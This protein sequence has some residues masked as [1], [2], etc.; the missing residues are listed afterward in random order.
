[1]QNNQQLETM[2]NTIFDK[3]CNKINNKLF[4]DLNLQNTVSNSNAQLG[5][6]MINENI[7]PKTEVIK[8]QNYSLFGYE[9]SVWYLILLILILIT[10]L[11]FV[12]KYFFSYNNNIV[13]IQKSKDLIQMNNSNDTNNLNSEIDSDDESTSKSSKSSKTSKSSKSSKSSKNKK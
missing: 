13:S 7:L 8:T 10:I 5:S 3:A 1:M 2:E 12:Y 9:F 6:S 11:Y 4:S